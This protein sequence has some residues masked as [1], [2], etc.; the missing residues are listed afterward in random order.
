LIDYEKDLKY[1]F[2]ESKNLKEKY[3]GKVILIKNEEVKIVGDTIEEV[4]KRTSQLGIDVSK[5]VVE[6]IPREDIT[7]IV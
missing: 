3:R 1:F 7:L 6:F 4:K 5:S 2:K